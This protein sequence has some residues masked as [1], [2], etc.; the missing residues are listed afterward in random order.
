MTQTETD[1]VNCVTHKYKYTVNKSLILHKP[2]CGDGGGSYK[3]TDFLN[4]DLALEEE[5]G[6]L[7]EG[8]PVLELGG[9]GCMMTPQV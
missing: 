6:R 1:C 7:L 4:A 2:C 8:V 3:S 5:K 9:L